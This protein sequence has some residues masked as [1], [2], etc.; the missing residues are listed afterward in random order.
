MPDQKTCKHRWKTIRKGEEYICRKCGKT[1]T[2]REAK[3][4]KE[5]G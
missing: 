3:E 4:Y 1:N 5:N 2:G